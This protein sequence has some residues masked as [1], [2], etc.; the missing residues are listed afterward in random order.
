M[1]SGTR[2]KLIEMN[3]LYPVPAGTKGTVGHVDDIGQIH[4]NWDNG[5]SLALI[6][7]LDEFEVL[8]SE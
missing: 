2:V 5:S 8:S 7:D 4:V 6:K 1:K 3:D